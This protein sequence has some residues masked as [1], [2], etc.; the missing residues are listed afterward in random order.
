MA[1]SGKDRDALEALVDRHT[2]KGV[3]NA[4]SQICED[5]AEHVRTNWQDENLAKNWD[6]VGQR[7]YELA[8]KVS[9]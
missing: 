6:H 2:A 9:V 7:C 1:W 4:L 3:L 8:A 5:K